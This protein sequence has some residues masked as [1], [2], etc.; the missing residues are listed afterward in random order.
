[1]EETELE[2]T[3][4]GLVAT[5]DAGALP[6]AGEA[7]LLPFLAAEDVADLGVLPALVASVALGVSGA[8]SSRKLSSASHPRFLLTGM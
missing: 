3:S 1:M 4:F 2:A 5:L 8:A 7:L 6:L